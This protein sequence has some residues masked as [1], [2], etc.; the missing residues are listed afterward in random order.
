MLLKNNVPLTY[1]VEWVLDANT[2][3]WLNFSPGNMTD[4]YPDAS[5]YPWASDYQ[6]AVSNGYP[7]NLTFIV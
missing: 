6:N 3:W 2:I 1:G 7:V 4:S 5:P